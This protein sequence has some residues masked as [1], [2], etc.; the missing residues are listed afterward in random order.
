MARGAPAQPARHLPK[1]ARPIN[2]ALAGVAAAIAWAAQQP[3]DKRVGG[4]C[5]DDIELLGKLI[6]RGRAWPAA[7]LALHLGNGA[8]FG[9]CYA[10]ARHAA[11]IE[12]V[13]ALRRE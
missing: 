3:L 12:P 11:A 8:A 1:V 2:G 4:S 6:T 10:P 5:Y 13:E 7:G 9:A